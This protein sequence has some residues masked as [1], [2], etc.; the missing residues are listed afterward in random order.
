LPHIALISGD[1]AEADRARASRLGCHLLT[2]PFSARE[3]I[4]WLADVERR[5]A[6]TRRLLDW[7][8]QG[9]R[10]VTSAES[11]G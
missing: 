7:N 11:E 4:S 9:W 3:L 1:W 2:K 10:P 6:P 8:A 5:V